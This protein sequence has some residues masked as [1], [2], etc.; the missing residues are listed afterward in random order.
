MK[1][2][3]TLAG[4]MQRATAEEKAKV[5]P[6]RRGKKGVLVFL[7]EDAAVRLKVL[8]AENKTSIQA[9]GEEAYGLLFEQYES[10]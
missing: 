8:A 4:A 10:R 7:E 6:S 1:E 5:A 3:A 2:K 9:L